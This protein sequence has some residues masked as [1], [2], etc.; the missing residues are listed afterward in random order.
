MILNV[1]RKILQM[2]FFNPPLHKPFF[3]FSRALMLYHFL[4]MHSAKNNHSNIQVH[5]T[6]CI[7]FSFRVK[8]ISRNSILHKTILALTWTPFVSPWTKQESNINL[9]VDCMQKSE[10]HKSTLC[11]SPLTLVLQ[12]I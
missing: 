9:Q 8:K 10:S 1:C 4:S 11:L 6:L 5:Q 2:F 12:L 7:N 3:L